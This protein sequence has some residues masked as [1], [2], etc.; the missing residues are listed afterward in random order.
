VTSDKCYGNDGSPRARNES[1]PLGGTDPYSASKAAT[2]LLVQSWPPSPSLHVC[3]VR[4]GNVIGGGDMA[5]HR[6]VP[7]FYRAL[8]NEE[9][10]Y[11]RTPSGIRPWQDVRDC[12]GAYLAVAE[13]LAAGTWPFDSVNVASDQ[14]DC[15]VE[16]IIAKLV[17]MHPGVEV[18]VGRGNS[19]EHVW[20]RLDTSR[21]RSELVLPASVPMDRMLRDADEIYTGMRNGQDVTAL[22]QRQ[23][24]EWL[25]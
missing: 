23:W 8:Q 12:L 9:P 25:R 15:A 2:E 10:L 7:D 5:P 4:G 20:L 18:N 21:I 14:D 19:L 16:S 24:T 1:D 6:L 22:L 13:R 11:L 17:E 3:T